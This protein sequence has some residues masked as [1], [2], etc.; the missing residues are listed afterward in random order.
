MILNYI[1]TGQPIP[2]FNFTE[3]N[4]QMIRE[5]RKKYDDMF[6][7]IRQWQ[8]EIEYEI[9]WLNEMTKVVS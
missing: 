5:M 1:R 7:L 3:I 2:H 8:A 9:V 6:P 4:K